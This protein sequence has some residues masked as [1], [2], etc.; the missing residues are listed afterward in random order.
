M[1]KLS[2]VIILLLGTVLALDIV[3]CRRF[4]GGFRGG[5]FRTRTGTSSGRRTSSFSSSSRRRFNA[6]YGTYSRRTPLPRTSL[7]TR[8]Y[9]GFRGRRSS[10]YNGFGLGMGA[11]LFI[12]YRFGLLH[13]PIGYGHAGY[14]YNYIHR[15]RGYKRESPIRCMAANVSEYMKKSN[16]KEQEI[17]I[18]EGEITCSGDE[19]VCYG[20]IAITEVNFTKSDNVSELQGFEVR[21][22]K[23]CGIKTELEA[24]KGNRAKRAAGSVYDEE[25][26]CWTS[27]VTNSDSDLIDEWTKTDSFCKF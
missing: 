5:G 7:Y 20:R 3:E 24:A 17:N 19:D 26:K 4:G 9:G 16:L 15:D 6:G 8:N 22:E 13:R 2:L 11:G 25:R 27:S 10:S 21:I 18:D 14:G 12:G 23:G 1:N